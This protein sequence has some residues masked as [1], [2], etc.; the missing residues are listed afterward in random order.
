MIAQWRSLLLFCY[1]MR[2]DGEMY[3]QDNDKRRRRLIGSRL[4]AA[5][6]DAFGSLTGREAPS[7]L[8]FFSH[9]ST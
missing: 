7:R 8:P 4:I 3:G 6:G 9:Q 5:G 1:I 2:R